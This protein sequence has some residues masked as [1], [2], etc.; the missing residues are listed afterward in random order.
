ME[1]YPD[2]NNRPIKEW[3][4]DEITGSFMWGEFDDSGYAFTKWDG[5]MIEVTKRGDIKICRYK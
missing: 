1:D 4:E 2:D 5:R 3:Y